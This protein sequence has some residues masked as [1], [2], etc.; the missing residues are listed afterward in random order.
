[1]ADSGKEAERREKKA[2]VDKGGYSD[3][4]LSLTVGLADRINH[5]S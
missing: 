5:I 3:S 2:E 4:A 1:L